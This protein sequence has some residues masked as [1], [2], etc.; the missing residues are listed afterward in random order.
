V[1]QILVRFVLGGALVAALPV[2]AQR[3]GPQT[4]GLALL[5]PA[6]SF[7][8]LL[9][10]G[11]SQGLPAVATASLAAVVG[12]PTVVAFLLAVHLSARR[13]M[14]LSVTLALGTLSWFAVAAPI[15]LW[16][17]RRRA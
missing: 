10:V 16:S 7:A 9:F 2:I 3:L 8:G 17:R 5:F 13:G 1:T 6:V 15:E 4:A 12:L 14:S 11:K